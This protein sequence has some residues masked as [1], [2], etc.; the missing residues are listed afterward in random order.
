MF[1]EREEEREHKSV[2]EIAWRGN[3]KVLFILTLVRYK[4]HSEQDERGT[5]H[6][7]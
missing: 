4:K 3:V 6:R 5:K 1:V 7:F 2:S